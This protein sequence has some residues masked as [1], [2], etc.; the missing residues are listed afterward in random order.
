MHETGKTVTEPQRTIPVLSEV[1]VVVVGA[2]PAGVA[3]SIAAA[4]NGARV[5]LVERY[6]Y[7]GGMATGGHVILLD[8]MSDD[9]GHHVI[10]GIAQ[11]MVD[12]LDEMGGVVYPPKNA[13]GSDDLELVRRW[14]RWGAVAGGKHV[15]Y[16]PVVNAEYFKVIGNR[17]LDETGVDTI[18]HAWVCSS[19]VEENQ[20]RGVVLESK[21]GRQAVLAGVTVDCTGDGDVFAFAGA[22]FDHN[23]FPPGLVFRVGGVDTKRA[24]EFEFENPEKFRELMTEMT[25]MGGVKGGIVE[26][27]VAPGGNYMHTTQESIVWFNNSLPQTDVLDVRDLSRVEKEVREQMMITLEFFKERIPGFERAYL[28]DTAPQLGTRS[29]RRLKGEHELTRDEMLS[30]EPVEDVIATVASGV[31]GRPLINIPYRCLL[32]ERIDNL[33]VAGRCISTD[34]VTQTIIRIIPTCMA[35]GQAAGTAAALATAQR[36]RPRD[37]DRTRLQERLAGD[38]Q[39]IGQDE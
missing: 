4:R 16:S 18:F 35:T 17:M 9:S 11:E 10:K 21:S 29:S 5:A 33:L 19:L 2:G 23:I 38:G 6:G 24:D 15:R 28:I 1:D 3:A 27:T 12:R 37:I 8:S 14:K 32:P 36:Q 20:M 22:D 7:V 25:Y 13:W 30:G 34:F 26:Q 39:Y 31:D